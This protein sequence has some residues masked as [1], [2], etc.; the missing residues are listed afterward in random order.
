MNT[1]P[2]NDFPWDLIAESLT[3]SITNEEELRLQQWLSSDPENNRKYLQIQEL[4]NNGMED[5][6]YYKMANETEAWKKLQ[7]KLGK[8]H[9]ENIKTLHVQEQFI[10]SPALLRNLLA[11]AALFI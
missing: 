11:I 6:R 4:W 9:P 7:I 1:S 8:D 2:K 10:K 3:G 5:Y